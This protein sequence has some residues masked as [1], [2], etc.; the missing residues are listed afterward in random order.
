MEN[1]EPNV[2]KPAPSGNLSFAI[3]NDVKVN[4]NLDA[5]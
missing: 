2:A 5:C 1:A 4:T 3:S